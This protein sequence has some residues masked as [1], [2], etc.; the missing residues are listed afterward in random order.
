[1]DCA[2]LRTLLCLLNIRPSPCASS[3]SRSAVQDLTVAVLAV[4]SS[5]PCRGQ[6]V[7]VHMQQLVNRWCA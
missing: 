4:T 1:V 5:S 3:F 7:K 6:S 2:P